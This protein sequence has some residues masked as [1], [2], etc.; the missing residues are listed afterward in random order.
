MFGAPVRGGSQ[1][2]TFQKNFFKHQ[3]LCMIQHQVENMLKYNEK[4]CFQTSEDYLK[5]KFPIS[6]S[7]FTNAFKGAKSFVFETKKGD[8]VKTLREKFQSNLQEEIK[9]LEKEMKL[10]DY[11]LHQSQMEALHRMEALTLMSPPFF[12]EVL[13]KSQQNVNIIL[14]PVKGP[15]RLLMNIQKRRENRVSYLRKEYQKTQRQMGFFSLSVYEKRITAA[16][17]AV[18]RGKQEIE[19][20]KMFVASLQTYPEK[21][22]NNF[23][24]C[25]VWAKRGKRNNKSWRIRLNGPGN[26]FGRDHNGFSYVIDEDEGGS[27]KGGA[28]KTLLSGQRG[29]YESVRVLNK[30]KY[31]HL[32]NILT[33]ELG[34]D[35]KKLEDKS[36]SELIKLIQKLRSDMAEENKNM[37]GRLDWKDQ[38]DRIVENQRRLLAG[39]QT[40]GEEKDNMTATAG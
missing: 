28:S 17:A 8:H 38:L 5:K 27:E 23:Y 24:N 6:M 2:R 25:H 4:T 21:I 22:V 29:G 39:K 1:L 31:L 40:L 13:N 16:D 36:K 14:D 15:L 35:E 10:E 9:E 11:C 12:R 19:C 18:Q 3:M 33:S 37:P 20:I 26:P 30:R 34:Q 7:L 32:R